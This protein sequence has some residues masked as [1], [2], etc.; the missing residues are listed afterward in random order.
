MG[1]RV[2]DVPATGRELS[3]FEL[4]WGGGEGTGGT[5][6]LKKNKSCEANQKLASLPEETVRGPKTE[7]DLAF[8]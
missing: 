4:T 1:E 5:R 3:P 6:C 2:R 7:L 8:S